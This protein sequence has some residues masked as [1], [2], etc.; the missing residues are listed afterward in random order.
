MAEAK[1]VEVLQIEVLQEFMCGMYEARTR[2]EQWDFLYATEYESDSLELNEAMAGMT[3][4]QVNEWF[5]KICT[6][7]ISKKLG[8]R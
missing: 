3:D 4:T 1:K 5:P 2:S 6:E 7:Y 8:M